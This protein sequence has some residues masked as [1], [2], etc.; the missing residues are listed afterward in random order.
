[1][2]LCLRR[3]TRAALVSVSFAVTGPLGAWPIEYEP[4]PPPQVEI[5]EIWADRITGGEDFGPWHT[6]WPDLRYS[7]GLN[8]SEEYELVARFTNIQPRCSL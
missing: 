8:Y 2:S 5:V 1:M 4:E 7:V 3:R 6:V